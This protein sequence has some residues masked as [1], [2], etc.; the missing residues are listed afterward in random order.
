MKK[1]VCVIIMISLLAMTTVAMSHTSEERFNGLDYLSARIAHRVLTPSDLGAVWALTTVRQTWN[2]V[3]GG[4]ACPSTTQ[5]LIDP[6]RDDVNNNLPL[7]YHDGGTD[8]PRCIASGQWIV[9]TNNA[10][11]D[12]Y[13]D[14]GLWRSRTQLV[15]S[16]LVN[17][18]ESGTITDYTVICA[19]KEDVLNDIDYA[20]DQGSIND[21]LSPRCQMYGEGT[22]LNDCVNTMCILEHPTG[23]GFGVAL[24]NPDIT[25]DQSFLIALNLAPDFCDDIL[26]TPIDDTYEECSPESS[27]L[28]NAKVYYNEKLQSLIFLEGR[29]IL[30][31][32]NTIWENKIVPR[33]ENILDYAKEHVAHPVINSPSYDAMQS[34]NYVMI[35]RTETQEI[36]SF[37]AIDKTGDRQDYTTIRYNGYVDLGRDACAR[38]TN[39]ELY[40]NP[41]G[42]TNPIITDVRCSS[43]PRQ[44]MFYVIAEGPTRSPDHVTLSESWLQLVG[45]IRLQP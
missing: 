18:G 20:I 28:T 43:Q 24:N 29:T 45:Q 12:H 34:F 11:N 1:V 4:H 8:S 9:S 21:I 36:F 40:S 5:C 17:V 31:I 22:G 37:K 13:C 16:E 3:G 30:P 27:D 2:V 44:G 6:T 25:N 33:Y 35:K 14:E 41:P 23:R 38:F 15:F 19:D 26:A 42:T 7:Q 10:E 39:F 32:T